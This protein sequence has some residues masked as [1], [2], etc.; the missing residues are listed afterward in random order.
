[1]PKFNCQQS[2]SNKLVTERTF[3][4]LHRLQMILTLHIC[5]EQR[6]AERCTCEEEQAFNRRLHG[7]KL[8]RLFYQPIKH[9]PP[10]RFH[11]YP[12]YLHVREQILHLLPSTAAPSVCSVT[13]SLKS[14][15]RNLFFF[16]WFC[17]NYC[18]ENLSFKYQHPTVLL[19]VLQIILVFKRQLSGWMDG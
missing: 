7:Q 9:T 13:L 4:I 10:A 17:F 3:L 19:L 15:R 2:K 1:M 18:C 8:Q 6:E 11:M 14:S 5:D 16:F 12:L